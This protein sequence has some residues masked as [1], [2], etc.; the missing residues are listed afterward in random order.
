MQGQTSNYAILRHVKSEIKKR[1]RNLKEEVP[2]ELPEKPEDFKDQYPH[3]WARA[4]PEGVHPT[5]CRRTAAE[6]LMVVAQVPMRMTKG[7]FTS[8]GLPGRSRGRSR[9]R[10]AT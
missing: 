7:A 8:P 1:R 6:V 10:G 4:F 2:E 3:L 5:P 9:L